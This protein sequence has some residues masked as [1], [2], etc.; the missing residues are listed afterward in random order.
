MAQA[1][2]H[3]PFERRVVSFGDQRIYE[4]TE[5]IARAQTEIDMWKE[6]IPKMG[7][8]K[9]CKGEGKTIYQVAQDESEWEECRTCKGNGKA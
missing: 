4:L 9:T 6:L 3:L 7:V 2:T 1:Y 5:I 8:C